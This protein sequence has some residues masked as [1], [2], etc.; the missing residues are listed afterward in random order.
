VKALSEES[1]WVRLTDMFNGVGLRISRG[2]VAYRISLVAPSWAFRFFDKI[3][4]SRVITIRHGLAKG[5][6]IRGSPLATLLFLAGPLTKEEQFLRTLKVKNK[7][8]YDIGAHIG[9]ITLFLAKA[10]GE[11]GMVVAFEPNPESYGMLQENLI[12]NSAR[13]ARSFQ[14][15]LGNK[16]HTESLVALRFASGT[17]TIDQEMQSTIVREPHSKFTVKICPLDQCVQEF[18][19]PIPDFVK[20]DVEGAEY[21]VLEGMENTIAKCKPTILIEIHGTNFEKSRDKTKRIIAFLTGYGYHFK[22]IE[23]G[24]SLSTTS[25]ISRPAEGHIL[26]Y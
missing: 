5:F 17:G 8:V 3:Y 10:V 1:K 23:T 15:G 12:L 21:E 14:I 13:N 6:K 25:I 18:K 24:K 22:H 16:A 26:A 9:V 20:I 4:K 2:R 19:I 7:S 11:G